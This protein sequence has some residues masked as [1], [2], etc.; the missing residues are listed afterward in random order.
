MRNP[1]RSR[2]SSSLLR[3]HSTDAVEGTGGDGW[4]LRQLPWQVI[5]AGS[6]LLAAAVGWVVLATLVLI[7]WLTAPAGDF[8]DVL[9]SATQL[10][11]LAHGGGL[12]MAGVRWTLVPLGIT[13]G[14][15]MLL[16][17]V[18]VGA[19]RRGLGHARTTRAPGSEVNRGRVAR[20]CMLATGGTYVLVVTGAGVFAGSVGQGLRTA[21][22]VLLLTTV[23]VGW[24]ACRGAGFKVSE[25]L[26]EWARPVPAAVAAATCTVLVGGA[27]ALAVGLLQHLERVT[28]IAAGLGADALSTI[29]LT[30]AQLLFLPNLVIWAGAWTM[31]AGFTFGQGSVVSPPSTDL[32]LLPSIPVLGAL[33][34][35]GPGLWSLLWLLTG[36]AAGAVAVAVVLRRSP[37]AGFEEVALVSGLAGVLAALLFTLLGVA[38]R[39]DLG[40]DRL[41]GLGPRLG[42]LVVLS[43]ALIGMSALV[44][45]MVAGAVRQLHRRAAG[46]HAGS[47]RRMDDHQATVRLGDKVAP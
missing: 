35:E 23:A 37:R 6:G 24:G 41:T 38:A 44:V 16:G 47:R 5:A 22:G 45:G 40:V 7:A 34:A 11:L 29:Q 1:M 43:G 33:P 19:A 20:A 8:G 4:E 36:I 30:L 18:T 42:E 31:G 9:H 15:A 21:I 27:A 12:T 25:A 28:A 26:P 32:G 13:A 17:F 3:I 10:W 39:G 14:L 2:R 46:A